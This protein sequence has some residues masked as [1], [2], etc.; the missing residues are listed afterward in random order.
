MRAILFAAVTLT[1]NAASANAQEWTTLDAFLEHGIQLTAKQRAALARGEV[2]GKRLNTMDVRD[3]AVFGAVQVDVPRSVFV[4]RQ[5][6]FL[7]GRTPT[8]PHL[9]SD[10]PVADNVDAIAVSDDNL[11]ELRPCRPKSCKFKLSASDMQTLRPTRSSGPEE[12]ARVSALVKARMLEYVADYR[13]RGN[14]AMLVVDDHDRGSV[15]TGDALSAMLEDSSYVFRALPSL[16]RWLMR[17]PRDSLA[18]A[19]QAIYWGVNAAP[20]T[21]RVLHIVHAVLYSPTDVPG[22][23]MSVLAK[24]QIYANHYFE[25]GLETL[26]AVDRPETDRITLVAIHR[27]RFDHLPTFLGIRSRVRNG[28][29]ERLLEE[30]SRLKREYESASR[31]PTR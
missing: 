20:R 24:K 27:F 1:V 14:A 4:A 17:Y 6:E 31:Q 22:V 16:G 12:R 2:V 25:A 28:M 26:V 30:L 3:V 23:G 19:T 7:G 8:P 13:R 21:R 10:P 9:F 18:D 11:R 5:L 29:Q 15:H